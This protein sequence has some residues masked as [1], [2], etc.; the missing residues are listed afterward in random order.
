MIKYSLV[1]RMVLALLGS[2]FFFLFLWNKDIILRMKKEVLSQKDLLKKDIFDYCKALLISLVSVYLIVHYI[3][4]PV[5]VKGTSMYPTLENQALGISN[6]IGFTLNGLKRFDIVI[7]HMNDNNNY[8]VKRIIGLPGE[9]ISYKEDKLYIN[10]EYVEEPFFDESYRASS[11]HP[12]TND[13]EEITLGENE[14]Y[15]LGDNRPSSRD[16]RY[17][18]PFQKEQLSCK[19]VFIFYPFSK[20]GVKSW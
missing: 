11:S 14:Y 18:G 16:S 19:G 5:Q 9:T 7:I 20:F 1:V 2:V 15:C 6:K 17:Y 12:F 4:L 10:G 3:F 8:L 13:F